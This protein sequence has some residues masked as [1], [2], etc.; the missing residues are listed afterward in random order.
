M[1]P[2]TTVTLSNEGFTAGIPSRAHNSGVLSGTPLIARCHSSLEQP[3]ATL[4]RILSLLLRA[5]ASA[6]LLAYSDVS[7]CPTVAQQFAHRGEHDLELIDVPHR[8]ALLGGVAK[9]QVGTAGNTVKWPTMGQ[10]TL[11]C[12]ALDA[13]AFT[14]SFGDTFVAAA[15]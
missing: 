6:P 12:V 2:T 3:R 11:P 4:N 7:A 14:V 13:D 10:L 15:A 5:M 8:T 9:I 1:L